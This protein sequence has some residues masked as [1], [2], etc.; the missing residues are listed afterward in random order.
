MLAIYI[1]KVAVW[2]TELPIGIADMQSGKTIIEPLKE[3]T[4]D[5]AA[6]V[7][8]DAHQR[9]VFAL[10]NPTSEPAIVP[11]FAS[12]TGC[13]GAGSIGQSNVGYIC[14]RHGATT[15][16]FSTALASPIR[17]SK[18]SLS[19]WLAD[20]ICG[21]QS[22]VL[23]D[24]PTG[25]RHAR[26]F[27]SFS[28]DN[29]RLAVF[30]ADM[31]LGRE[32]R[33]L[34]E[35]W[36][37][38]GEMYADRL[39]AFPISGDVGNR[40]AWSADGRHL[41]AIPVRQTEQNR[42]ENLRHQAL[43]HGRRELLSAASWRGRKQ[44]C[45]SATIRGK[46]QANAETKCSH[47]GDPG[48]GSGRPQRSRVPTPTAVWTGDDLKQMTVW[49][50]EI[51]AAA[52]IMMIDFIRACPAR[53]GPVGQFPFTNAAE[54]LIELSF[55]DQESVVLGRDLAVGIHVIQ[56]GAVFGRD[57]LERPPALGVGKAKHLRQEHSRHLTIMGCQNR[58]VEIDSHALLLSQ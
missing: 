23:L 34:I 19:R 48:N 17:V 7:T 2:G 13:R 6:F 12:A 30:Y 51:D 38:S 22:V 26:I 46:R 21:T 56:V 50:F 52:A 55:A 15:V 10:S 1:Y 5:G 57:H 9:R 40:I 4:D 25:W 28:Q 14:S 35:V 47:H 45:V 11:G 16:L 37:M 43:T 42:S 31:Q 44:Q 39:A 41:A 36:D 24:P 33:T 27:S 29:A 18:I 53:I 32:T 8:E 3:A 54:D 58:V 49:V 20:S